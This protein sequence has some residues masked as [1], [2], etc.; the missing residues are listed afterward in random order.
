[1]KKLKDLI[2]CDLDIEVTGVADDSRNVKEGYAY[3]ATKGYNVDHYDYI[4]MAINNGCSCVIA[5]RKVNYD[6]P[7]VVIDNINE[8]FFEIC[9]KFFDINL[10]DFSFIGVTGTDG[11]TT[12]TFII[13]ELMSKFIKTTYIGTNGAMIGNKLKNVHNTTPIVTELYDVLK[14]SKD[15]DS[16]NIVMEVSSEALLHNLSLIHI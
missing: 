2:D 12:T 15:N 13:E 8:K 4:E 6:I 16:Y 7:Y 3:I 11:K 1:M 9:A 10:D 14:W 5:D